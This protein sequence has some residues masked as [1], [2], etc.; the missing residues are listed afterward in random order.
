[1]AHDPRLE[2][3]ID[4]PREKVWRCWTEPE[5]I[6]QWFC[7]RPWKVVEATMDTRAGGANSFLMKGPNGEEFSNR[8]VYLEVAPGRKLVFTDA[9]VDGWTP[10]GKAFMVATVTFDDAPDGRTNYVAV[11]R[12]WSAEDREAHEKMGFHE[13]WG[14]AADQ[15]EELARTL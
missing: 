2:R 14:K 3:V 15:L 13:G 1:M 9:F 5:L 4:A 12:H 8:G 11:A 10:S 7:P 6:K